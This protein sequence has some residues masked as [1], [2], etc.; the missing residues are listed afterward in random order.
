[1]DYLKTVSVAVLDCTQNVSF[2]VFHRVVYFM[3]RIYHFCCK[4]G[5]ANFFKEIFNPRF[6]MIL[7]FCPWTLN[8]PIAMVL[9]R[10]RVHY[11]VEIKCYKSQIRTRRMF[12]LTK[13]K[14]P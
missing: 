9:L 6:I 8:L 2:I 10:L 5:I 11:S 14:R 1:M 7:V 13:T 3:K 4:F 12:L